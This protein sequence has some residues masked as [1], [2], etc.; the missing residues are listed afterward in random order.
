MATANAAT[1]DTAAVDSTGYI[2]AMLAPLQ[3]AG[4]YCVSRN[5]TWQSKFSGRVDTM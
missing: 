2:H 5:L 4:W 1:G 3:Q